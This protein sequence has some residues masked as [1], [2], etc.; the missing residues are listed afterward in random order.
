MKH[1][2]IHSFGIRRDNL[3]HLYLLSDN[4]GSFICQ[5]APLEER[6]KIESDFICEPN[7]FIN[8]ASVVRTDR[9]RPAPVV[10]SVGMRT[11]AGVVDVIRL[12]NS[13]LQVKINGQV[14]FQPMDGITPFVEPQPQIINKETNMATK[15]RST[16]TSVGPKVSPSAKT[17]PKAQEADPFETVERQILKT[18]K[19]IRLE[20][21]MKKN[22][23]ST[24]KE[25]LI[26]FFTKYNVE[27][28]TIFVD[29]KQIQT[30]SGRRRS[31][32]DIYMICKY[33][34]PKCTMKEIVTLLFRD[35]QTHFKQGFRY[36]F[37][38]VIK[39]RVFYYI[40]GSRDL[41]EA[42]KDE[43]GHLPEYYTSKI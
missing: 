34:Y 3:T 23:P 25:F 37:C 26:N 31:L 38:G 39:K 13:R 22:L 8:S 16:V 29:D 2:K 33:Y 21:F 24:L 27:R 36:S 14:I 9:F 42:S 12:R 30:P 5:T 35:L 1:Y 10:I 6:N 18:E 4:S 19:P 7:S 32:G 20:K 15:S 40:Q 11:N 28:N 41:Q 17:A 43:F